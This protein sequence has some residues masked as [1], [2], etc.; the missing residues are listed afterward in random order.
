MRFGQRSADVSDS[1]GKYLRAF[2]KGDNLVRWLEEINDWTRYYEH[3]KNNKGF[4][5]TG[6]QQTC[7]GCSS[8]DEDVQDGRKKYATYVWFV[9]MNKVLPVKVPSSLRD[10]MVT[11]AE[12][13]DGTVLN[14]D[15]VVIRS[16]SM[17][18][19]EY[20]VDKDEAYDVDIKAKL[21]ESPFTVQEAL[22]AAYRDVWGSLPDEDAPQQD[23]NAKETV[24]PTEPA[25]QRDQGKQEDATLTE[26]DVWE[27]DVPALRNLCDKAGLRYEKNATKQ[28]LVVKLLR[29]FAA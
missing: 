14:R 17:L 4:P 7:P 25:S 11:R 21:K 16:G 8:P 26:A 18:D 15:F 13:N 20:D 27:M 19:T 6:D 5:C 12:R 29:E 9:K 2:K 23:K 3:R 1:E 28:D 10:R 24:P 22:E